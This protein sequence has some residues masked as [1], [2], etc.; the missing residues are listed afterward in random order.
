[1]YLIQ[2]EMGYRLR[3]SILVWGHLYEEKKTTNKEQWGKKT[4]R[5]IHPEQGNNEIIS[6]STK[7]LYPKQIRVL[8]SVLPSIHNIPPG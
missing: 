4:I 6:Q 1:M 8:E 7:I 5:E 2:Y 3:Y